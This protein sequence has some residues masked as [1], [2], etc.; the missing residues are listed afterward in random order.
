MKLFIL[1]CALTY[2]KALPF[3]PIYSHLYLRILNSFTHFWLF[4]T[5]SHSCLAHSYT[6]QTH[7]QPCAD[8]LTHFQ[9]ISKYLYLIQPITY[10]YNSYF[11]PVFT[12]LYTLHTCVC[13]CL[14][15][16]CVH[17]PMQS[18]FMY[19][20]A[21]VYILYMPLHVLILQDYLLALSYFKTCL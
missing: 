12:G 17:V 2:S 11:I 10:H 3:T 8:Y 9:S 6:F 13:M 7:H 14:C 19:F 21:S 1:N 20:T 4:P 18:I 5:H 16:S 15:A